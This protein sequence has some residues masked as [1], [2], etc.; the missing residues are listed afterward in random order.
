MTERASIYQAGRGTALV[1]R[2]C[3][4]LLAS[5]NDDIVARCWPLVRDGAPVAA[6]VE[7]LTRN[8]LGAMADFAL[9]RAVDGD[10]SIVLVRG[11]GSVTAS[12]AE[13]PPLTGRAASTWIEA[14]LPGLI[15][16]LAVGD[17][18]G[19][20]LLPLQSGVVFADTVE[21]QL[22]LTTQ[23]TPDP[24]APE[25]VVAEPVASE[26]AAPEPVVA[27]PAAPEPIAAEPVAAA[28]PEAIAEPVPEPVSEGAPEPIAESSV[29]P[30]GHTM[31]FSAEQ[32]T[33]PA[34]D[35]AQPWSVEPDADGS[36][37]PPPPIEAVAAAPG[38]VRAVRCPYEH[39]SPADAPNCRVC[40]T[41]IAAQDPVSV[42]RPALGL[43]RFSTGDVVPLDRGVLLGR[44][45]S[46]DDEHDPNRPHL[47]ALPSPNKDISRT[48]AEVRLGDWTVS[49]VDLGSTNGTTVTVPGQTPVR[50][51]PNE[52][53]ELAPNAE[54]NLADEVVFRFEVT[55]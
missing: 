20:P 44:S 3:A 35:S 7:E 38:T 34:T 16:H 41:P 28:E 40:G 25:P 45:P 8:G 39:L 42:G 52:P 22:Q 29:D 36:F 13:A 53:F 30:A 19:G 48:H 37:P 54:V 5:A 50:L 4:L 18:S 10:R 26:P 27:E 17:P 11:S 46:A 15:L 12:G 21:A 31:M 2:Q 24:A 32:L 23:P 47:V 9:A 33:P 49:V 55:A 6:L 14:E 43:L 1:G 51:N